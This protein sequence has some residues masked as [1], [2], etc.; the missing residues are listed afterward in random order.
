MCNDRWIIAVIVSPTIVRKI[1]FTSVLYCSL[2]CSFNKLYSLLEIN[3]LKINY[4][5]INGPATVVCILVF[6]FADNIDC[7]MSQMYIVVS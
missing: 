2:Y 3:C 7:F 4:L 1:L 6:E 5:K